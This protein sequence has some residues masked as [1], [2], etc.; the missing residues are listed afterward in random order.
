MAGIQSVGVA[1]VINSRTDYGRAAGGRWRRG[2]RVATGYIEVLPCA[3]HLFAIADLPVEEG[4]GRNRL[5]ERQYYLGGSTSCDAGNGEVETA[6]D[7]LLCSRAV[8]ADIRDCQ[9]S[10]CC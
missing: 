5:A 8:S 7:T 10:A 9:S 6:A 2:D 1:A 4:R 3:P